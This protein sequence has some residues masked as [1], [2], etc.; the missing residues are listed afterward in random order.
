MSEESKLN[1]AGYFI[2]RKVSSWLVTLIL[3]IGGALAF[4]KLGQL[5]DPEFT[6]KDALVITQYPGASPEQVE[7]EVTYP[8]ELE[9]QNLPYVDE[10][11]STSKGGY[12]KVQITIKDT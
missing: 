8:I 11:K 6:I 5:E 12:S 10:I 7:E 4:T 9:L 2:E 1:I 3:L